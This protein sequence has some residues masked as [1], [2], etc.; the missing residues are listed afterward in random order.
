[1]Q[2]VGCHKK[3]DTLISFIPILEATHTFHNSITSTVQWKHSENIISMEH[4]NATWPV[5][6]CSLKCVSALNFKAQKLNGI[7]W[8]RLFSLSPFKTKKKEKKRKLEYRKAKEF[9]AMFQELLLSKEYHYTSI[10]QLSFVHWRS[11]SVLVVI[12]TY[13]LY[14][15]LIIITLYSKL[16]NY[17]YLQKLSENI[18]GAFLSFRQ[19]PAKIVS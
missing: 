19:H 14:I 2:S 4:P 9:R 7:T 17:V 8:N 15:T 12:Q 11:H 16:Q 6:D 3:H 13:R 18:P 10:A 1:M 5:R